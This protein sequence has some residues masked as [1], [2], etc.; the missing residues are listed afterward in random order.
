[1]YWLCC[2]RAACCRRLPGRDCETKLVDLSQC[3][4][5]E[6]NGK[7]TRKGFVVELCDTPDTARFA[8]KL[9]FAARSK[10]RIEQQNGSLL[11]EHVLQHK[12]VFNWVLPE[13]HSLA[14]RGW[15]VC[16]SRIL[17]FKD[18]KLKYIGISGTKVVGI[19]CLHMTLLFAQPSKLK[20]NLEGVLQ[21]FRNQFSKQSESAGARKNINSRH[22]D[23][24]N[25]NAR[26]LCL[27]YVQ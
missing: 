27:Q 6:C 25:K 3:V 19:K 21:E 4:Q 17:L 12:C 23:S 18:S 2:I 11:Y 1:M 9:L 22:V 5:A 7:Q 24:C 8:E 10:W 14:R 16:Y 20:T 26:P 15:Q 13:H